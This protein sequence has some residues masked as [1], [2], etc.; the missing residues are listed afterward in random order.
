MIERHYD[1]EA[2]VTILASRDGTADAHLANCGECSEK[3]DSF[4]LVAEALAD[5]ATWDKRVLADAPDPKTI[6]TLRAFADNLAAEDEA[7]R[8]FLAKLL[9][10]PREMWMTTLDAHPEYRTAGTVR[11]LIAATDRALDTMPADAVAITALAVEIA[12]ELEAT[13][14]R[15]D[16]LARLRGGAWRE[17][18]YALFYTGRFAE[19]E[20]AVGLAERHFGD[21]VVDEYDQARVGIVRAMVEKGLEHLSAGISAAASSANTF[22]RFGDEQRLASANLAEVHLLFGASDFRR[23]HA[24]LL[25]LEENVRRTDDATHALVLGNLGYCARKLH[26]N[27]EALRY[28]EQ[29]AFL[30]DGLGNAS[31]S[32]RVRWNVASLLAGEGRIAEALDRFNQVRNDL[33]ALGMTGAATLV[34]LEIAELLLIREDFATVEELC[35]SAIDSIAKSGLA[36]TARALTALGLMAEAVR[37]RTVTPA[38]VR[39]VR[40]YVRRLPAEPHLLFTPAP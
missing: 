17:H 16:T 8:P 1:E 20:Q 31:E 35:Q 32:A 39:Q 21:C 15:P 2:L 30:L 3:L 25:A 11:G 33:S 13:A 9:S 7:A 6:A 24:T 37:S 34:T 12:D 4:R 40:E 18:A 29:A 10:G 27:D 23:A 14:Y 38:F 5:S 28:Y 22:A 26:L 36:H 19:A